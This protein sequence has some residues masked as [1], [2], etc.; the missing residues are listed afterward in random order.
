MAVDKT[1]NISYFASVQYPDG[2]YV[3]IGLAH[4]S[5]PSNPTSFSKEC[6]SEMVLAAAV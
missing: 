5:E 3:D 2:R 6:L 4:I 1:G